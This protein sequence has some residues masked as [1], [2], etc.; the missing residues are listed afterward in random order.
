MKKA[1]RGAFFDVEALPEG[2]IMIFPIA[3]KENGWTPFPDNSTSELYFGGLKS[4][5]FGRTQVT[6][7][8]EYFN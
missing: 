8:G 4:I 7:T 3:L 5:G 6:L 2:S 1:K